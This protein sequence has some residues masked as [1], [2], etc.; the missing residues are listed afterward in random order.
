MECSLEELLVALSD[1]LW[2]GKREAKLE[3][4]VINRLSKLT[5]QDYW[6]LFIDLDNHFEMIAS[7][8]EERLV[9]S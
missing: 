4:E 5:G 9:R 2:K 3:E 7:G 8:G 1:K 6:H